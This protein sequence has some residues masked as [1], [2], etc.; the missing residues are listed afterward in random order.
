MLHLI[1][2]RPNDIS[3]QHIFDFQRIRHREFNQRLGWGLNHIDAC[4]F[5][6]YDTP[7]ARYIIAY[8]GDQCVGGLRLAPTSSRYRQDG[9]QI[10]YMIRDFALGYIASPFTLDD[11]SEPL[12]SSPQVWEM[13]RF[14]SD[15]LPTTR[16]LLNAADDFLKSQDVSDVLTISPVQF[17]KLLR[18]LGFA[19]RSISAPIVFDD[20]MAYQALCTSV[21]RETS[22]KAGVKSAPDHLVQ[23]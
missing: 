13:T 15:G 11:F 8:R 3:Q 9:R 10:T 17:P 20:G 5:D 7:A 6:E 23:A 14:V 18:R 19:C 21:G 1:G 2:P 16:S 22:P 4:E 12:P